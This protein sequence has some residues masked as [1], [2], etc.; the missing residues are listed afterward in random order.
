MARVL[1]TGAAGYL[2]STLA[3]RLLADG[4]TVTV[5]DDFRYTTSSLL[6]C[7]GHERFHAERGDVRDE[8]T[9]RR[10]LREAD[11]IIPL[12]AVVGA[13][14]CERA[15]FEALS[16]N[17]DAVVL[18]NKLRA[19]TQRVLFPTTNSGYGHTAGTEPCTETSPLRPVS[20]YGR[21]KVE[22]EAELLDSENAVTFRLATVFGVSP[23]LRLDLLVNDFT[24]RAWR[25]KSLI[26]FEGDFVRNFVSVHDVAAL[27]SWAVEQD[28]SL[29]DGPYNFGLSDANLTKIQL[30]EI[31]ESVIP[32]FTWVE[33]DV[34]E[35]PD[36]RNYL[37]SNARIEAA[38]FRAE[39]SVCAGVNELVRAFPMLSPSHYGNA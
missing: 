1:V 19:R 15:P 25:E 13:P 34:G 9:L 31:I 17:R 2:G 29:A 20:L 14:A 28:A 33:S 18:L 16:T 37:V 22:A 39:T 4:H 3:P 12:A 26:V 23:R 35:D 10:L 36:R 32:D 6:A 8:R 24:W 11:V 38:G 27:F 30:C 7:A 5:L 21:S